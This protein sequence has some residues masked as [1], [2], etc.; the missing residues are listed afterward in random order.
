V[1]AVGG[2]REQ[3]AAAPSICPTAPAH[4]CAVHQRRRHLDHGRNVASFVIIPKRF[5]LSLLLWSVVADVE[6]LRSGS[7]RGPEATLSESCL[8]RLPQ[9]VKGATVAPR[10]RRGADPLARSTPSLVRRPAHRL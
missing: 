2:G 4:G 8:A 3:M 5:S 6:V 10:L 9:A 7:Q 1:T